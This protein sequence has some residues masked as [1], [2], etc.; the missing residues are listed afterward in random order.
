[1]ATIEQRIFALEQAINTA[2][3]LVIEVNAYPTEAQKAEIDR[4]V[5]SGRRLLVFYMPDDSA[6]MVGHGV[7]PWEQQKG[8]NCHGNN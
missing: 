6:W 3:M 7:P 2:P 1:M 4:A 8:N 5:R